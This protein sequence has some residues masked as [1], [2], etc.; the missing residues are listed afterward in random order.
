LT[1]C[2]CDFSPTTHTFVLT[3]TIQTT[4]TDAIVLVSNSEDGACQSGDYAGSASTSC[5]SSGSVSD[6]L[7]VQIVGGKLQFAYG[8]GSDCSANS[9]YVGTT[10][11]N[12]V[13]VESAAPI[14]DGQW[15]VVRASRPGLQRSVLT[16]DGVS[17][18]AA[19]DGPN[20]GI[21]LTEPLYIGGHPRVCHK[22][23]RQRMVTRW[24]WKINPSGSYCAQ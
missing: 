1:D 14:N 16:I 11:E 13:V 8:L 3:F 19:G 17:V 23:Q 6:H 9:G 5:T 24:I 22:R 20:T 21:D 12:N 15:H 4:A 18:E 2:A 10:C 7:V